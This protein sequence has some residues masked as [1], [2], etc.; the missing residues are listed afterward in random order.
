[1]RCQ[2]CILSD[3]LSDVVIN[4]KNCNICNTPKSD[5]S[6]LQQAAELDLAATINKLK[7]DRGVSFTY[8]CVVS[9]SGGKDSAYILLK[10]LKYKLNILAVTADTGF[11][12]KQA[13]KNINSIIKKL[14]V[15]HIFIKPHSKFIDLY[16][17]KLTENFTD[18][19]LNHICTKCTL[20]ME[21]HI[22]QLAR[23]IKIPVVFNGFSVDEIDALCSIHKTTPE[24]VFYEQKY[25]DICNPRSLSPLHIWND[26]PDHIRKKLALR[27]ILPKK[28]SSIFK[29]N[30]DINWLMIYNNICRR[31]YNPYIYMFSNIIR[32]SHGSRLKFLFLDKIIKITVRLRLFKP[33]FIRHTLKKLGLK[34]KDITQK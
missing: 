34:L 21:D 19:I 24:N 3:K 13:R 14:H 18:N 31:N 32:E 30:C 2:K 29:T 28:K 26:S 12:S 11:L 23:S 9:L 6:K 22:F 7:Y 27:Q 8:D 17:N 1:M 20:I 16:K 5:Y 15:D 25:D 10:L 33:F 4:D